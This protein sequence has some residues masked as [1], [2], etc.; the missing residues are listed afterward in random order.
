MLANP[1]V[2]DATK[3][4]MLQMIQQRGQVQS[5]KVPGGTMQIIPGTGQHQFIPEEVSAPIESGSTKVQGR[6]V[7]DPNTGRY[8]VQ[9]L[10]PDAPA[11]GATAGQPDLSSIGALQANEVAQAGAKKGAEKAAETDVTQY[12]NLHKGLAG[13]GM[14]AADSLP[15]IQIAK[16]AIEDPNFYS[17]SGS[18]AI[19]QLKKM[20]VATGLLPETAT[21]P[22]EAL[23]KVMASNILQQ[24]N[25]LKAEQ[26]AMG[27]TGGRIFSSQIELM[28][29]A[30]QNP[31]NSVAANRYLTNLA[32]WSA[33]R[34]MAVANMADDYKTTH[35]RLDANFEKNVRNAIATDPEL[36]LPKSLQFPDAEAAKSGSST[37]AQSAIEAEMRKR[38]LLKGPAAP[39]SQ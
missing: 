14:T 11:G 30:A 27:Q 10:L 21:T 5:T 39:V 25:G 35:G 7:Y 12:S 8:H 2:P 23:S 3:A 20:G 26:E 6:A 24:I 19:L 36:A 38:G 33:K 16:G 9:T 31:G 32:E 29:K 22:M 37:P 15:Y 28:E 4:A 13:A 18:D 34:Q 17:G 1:W